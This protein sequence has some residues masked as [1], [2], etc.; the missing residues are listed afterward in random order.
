MAKCA[1][2]GITRQENCE[3]MANW[4]NRITLEV[5]L[6]HITQGGTDDITKVVFDIHPDEVW[7]S[8]LGYPCW[9]AYIRWGEHPILVSGKMTIKRNGYCELTTYKVKAHLS[10][11]GSMPSKTEYKCRVVGYE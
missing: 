3:T 4:S 9:K 5:E 6:P 7:D 11:D 10:I 1:Y 8:I 2:I